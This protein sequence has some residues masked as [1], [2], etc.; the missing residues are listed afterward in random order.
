[1][2][3]DERQSS[4]KQLAKL[5][6]INQ[7][8][9]REKA[10]RIPAD[11]LAGVVEQYIEWWAFVLWARAIVEAQGEIPTPVAAALDLRCPGF[12]TQVA[13]DTAPEFWLRLGQWIDENVFRQANEAGWLIGVAY[14][15]SRELRWDQLWLYWEHCDERWQGARP[16]VYPTF[17]AWHEEAQRWR[18]PPPD[19]HHRTCEGADRV[20]PEQLKGAVSE[21]LDWE[22]FAYWVRAAMRAHRGMAGM[23]AELLGR[24]CPGFLE[25][26][27]AEGVRLDDPTTV[28]R[29]LLAWV[30]DR[31]FRT[32]K[33]EGWLEAVTFYARRSLAADR[34]V[35]YW[36][37]CDRRWSR[38][39][40]DHCP[41]FEEWRRAAQL[42]TER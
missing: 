30:A 34:I 33:A 16:D 18:F 2:K 29:R 42:Y 22:A 37:A 12:R 23:V 15:A 36:A 7:R 31:M 13:R 6:A 25:H 28:W 3:D 8:R 14:Y 1:M 35:A 39:R 32:A 4:R 21:F 26:L 5:Q 40:P 41:D 20:A 10:R 11:T 19:R 17:E 9:A 38:R 27:S 24:R